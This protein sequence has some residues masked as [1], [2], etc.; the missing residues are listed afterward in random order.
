MNYGYAFAWFVDTGS[1]ELSYH[2]FALCSQGPRGFPYMRHNNMAQI[3]AYIITVLACSH[4]VSGT[5]TQLQ[6]W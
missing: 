5:V 2:L 1:N 3:Q 6:A 4:S